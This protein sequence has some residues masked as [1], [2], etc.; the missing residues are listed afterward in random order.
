MLLRAGLMIAAIAFIDWRVEGNIPL[1]F[2]YL[3]PMLLA[4]SALKRWEIGAVAAI[5]TVLT[6]NFDTFEWF[7]ESGIPRDI[8]IFAAFFGMGL[9]VYEVVRNRQAALQH[10]REI[11]TE[12]LARREAEE[13]LKVLVESSPA[14]IFTTNGDGRVLLANNAAHRLFGLEPGTLAGQSIGEFLPALVNISSNDHSRQAFRTVMQCRGRRRDGEVFLADVWFST[15]AT[16]A[17]PR[18]AAMV[19]DTSEELRTREEFSLHQLL[20]GSRILVG[21]VSHEIR[22]VCGAIAV[23]H[24]NLARSGALANNKDFQA[25]GTLIVAL[26]K[27]AAMDLRQTNDSA[28]SVDLNSLLEELRIVIEPSLRDAGVEV[29]WTVEPDLPAVWADRQSL[30]QVFLN[31]AKNAERAMLE[32]SARELAVSARRDKNRIVVQFRDT[33][34][35][36]P[37]PDRLFQ[38]FQPGA[39]ATGLGLYLS[40]AFMRSFRGDLRYESEPG[41]S[42]FIVELSAALPG[43][44][45]ETYGPGNPDSIGGRPQLVPRGAQPVARS[46]A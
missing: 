13:Q 2:L 23:V 30:M 37:A 35:G 29:R 46:R 16:S 12:V 24:A 31:L 38:P 15:Y 5:C 10:L 27:I 22:N 44:G 18:L 17:G 41:G 34:G 32:R 43:N 40:R 11:E 45:M 20:A 25:L 1:G 26:E 19:V 28:A 14:A 39:H 21:A 42:R 33:G 8:L 7:P 3:F 4:G 36:V 6:E 9:F